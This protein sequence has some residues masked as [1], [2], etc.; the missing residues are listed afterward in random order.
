MPGVEIVNF[1][2]P[3]VFQQLTP[4][5]CGAQACFLFFHLFFG[6]SMPCFPFQDL[7]RRRCISSFLRELDP[8]EP[9][10]LPSPLPCV[11]LSHIVS[12]TFFSLQGAFLTELFSLPCMCFI[13]FPLLSKLSYLAPL[14]LLIRSTSVFSVNLF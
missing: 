13:R 14:H 4:Y 8:V 12:P 3:F 7:T 6:R 9:L 1:N 2:L 11:P 10:Q 5:L